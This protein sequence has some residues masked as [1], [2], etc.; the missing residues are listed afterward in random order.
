MTD[1]LVS[2]G[3]KPVI[4][5]DKEGKFLDYNFIECEGLFA[6]LHDDNHFYLWIDPFN[7]IID[8][9]LTP[10]NEYQ[11]KLKCINVMAT[12]RTLISVL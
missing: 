9:V 11:L 10:Q 8:T 4:Q 3:F 7:P 1:Y 5:I 6:E 12:Y 2:I